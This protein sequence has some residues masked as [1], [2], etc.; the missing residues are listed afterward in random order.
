MLW[1]VCV[2]I[3][4]V[5]IADSKAV[6]L[7]GIDIFQRVLPSFLPDRYLADLF[8]LKLPRIDM[9]PRSVQQNICHHMAGEQ[10]APLNGESHTVDVRDRRH[11]ILF[12]NNPKTAQRKSPAKNLE[13]RVR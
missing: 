6:D 12:L 11:R 13:M 10:F 3:D 4:Q 1:I 9:H 8:R 7:E 5:A 2:D